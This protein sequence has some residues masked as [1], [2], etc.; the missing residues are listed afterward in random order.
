[1]TWWWEF[2][3]RVPASPEGVGGQEELKLKEGGD[4]NCEM[5]TAGHQCPVDWQC[6]VSAQEKAAIQ[7]FLEDPDG[8]GVK[9]QARTAVWMALKLAATLLVAAG[10]GIGVG[11]G[12]E[13]DGV[14]C[15]VAAKPPGFAKGSEAGKKPNGQPAC[16]GGEAPG[17]GADG[18]TAPPSP[19]GFRAASAGIPVLE[20]VVG[21][22]ADGHRAIVGAVKSAMHRF[23]NKLDAVASGN[24]ELLR[25]NGELRALHKDGFLQVCIEGRRPG[26]PSVCGDYGF[27]EPEGGGGGVEGAGANVL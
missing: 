11:D 6:G 16:P 25:E 18:G 27:G 7:C 24:F 13:F 15:G 5:G 14:D 17:G 26:F 19:S 20:S 8:S 1:V 3:E 22:V 9:A 23:E 4:T 2:R 21:I 12:N 10:V